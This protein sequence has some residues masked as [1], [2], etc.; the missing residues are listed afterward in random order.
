MSE[1]DKNQEDK[2]NQYDKL[3]VDISN[4]LTTRLVRPDVETVKFGAGQAI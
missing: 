3:V 1:I 4:N 2:I